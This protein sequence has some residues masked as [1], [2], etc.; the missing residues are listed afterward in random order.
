MWK[1]VEILRAACCVAGLDGGVCQDELMLLQR[2]ASEVG[3]GSMS[4]DAMIKRAEGDSDF[5]QEL[6]QYVSAD[7]EATMKLL[8]RL[9]I[10][11]RELHVNERVV[12]YEF[13]KRLGVSEERYEELLSAAETEIE[14]STG[15]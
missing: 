14:D 5:Y 11:D 8:F 2:L 15:S 10:A 13:S 4:L 12:L 3:V 7:A 6:F 1:E 9:A